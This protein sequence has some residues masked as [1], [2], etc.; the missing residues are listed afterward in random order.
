[1]A[2]PKPRLS[3]LHKP[4]SLDAGGEIFHAVQKTDF[5]GIVDSIRFLVAELGGVPN[6]IFAFI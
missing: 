4:E 1:M 3:P 5:K 6:P 2:G